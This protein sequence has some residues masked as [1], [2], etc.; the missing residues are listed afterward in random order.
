MERKTIMRPNV[1]SINKVEECLSLSE[2]KIKNPIR[3]KMQFCMQKKRS[4]ECLFFFLAQKP[5]IA[6][7]H[8]EVFM[9]Y[10]PQ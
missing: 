6:I 2:K 9:N 1:K 5:L 8:D 10:E 3:E 4:E 7:M